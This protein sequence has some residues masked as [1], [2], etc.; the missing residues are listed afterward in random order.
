MSALIK[1]NLFAQLGLAV[2]LVLAAYLARRGRLQNHCAVMRIA[3]LVQILSIAVVMLPRL[4]GY[5]KNLQPTSTLSIEIWIHHLLGLA[6]VAIWVYVNLVMMGR[7]KKR[8]RLRSVMRL[9]FT[10]WLVSLGLGIHIYTSI[11][12]WPWA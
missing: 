8:G 4:L 5:V 6:V 12:G 10:L 7:I 11:W 1:I 2:I 9:A 3:V